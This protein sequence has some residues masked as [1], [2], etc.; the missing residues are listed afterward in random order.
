M[1]SVCLL[2]L[3]WKAFGQGLNCC[4]YGHHGVLMYARRDRRTFEQK[5]RGRGVS[6]RAA[7]IEPVTAAERLPG[8]RVQWG[9]PIPITVER[10]PYGRE[11]IRALLNDEECQATRRVSGNGAQPAA[12]AII[13]CGTRPRGRRTRRS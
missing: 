9:K 11:G 5:L 4:H 13:V 8:Y 12:V 2:F 3:R 10:R 1:R 6:F 7:P